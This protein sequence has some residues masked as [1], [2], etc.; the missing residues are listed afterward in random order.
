MYV[1]VSVARNNDISY[2]GFNYYNAYAML[3]IYFLI[4]RR[5]SFNIKPVP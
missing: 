5:V 3:L 4:S 2:C 1:D